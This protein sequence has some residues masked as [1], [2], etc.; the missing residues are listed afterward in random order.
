[1][2]NCM[3]REYPS[4]LMIDSG[5]AAELE[6]WRWRWSV[7]SR[8]MESSPH[9]SSVCVTEDVKFVGHRNRAM[10]NAGGST[11]VELHNVHLDCHPHLK[12]TNFFN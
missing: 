8:A 1:M 10:G 11:W 2:V 9:F 4:G 12:G 3:P 6:R 5:E 7:V